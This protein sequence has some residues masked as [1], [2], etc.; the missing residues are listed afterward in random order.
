MFLLCSLQKMLALEK[1]V[2]SNGR[3]IWGWL[4]LI[5]GAFSFTSFLYAA[6]ISKLQPPSHNVIIR[7]IQNDWYFLRKLKKVKKSNGQVLAINEVCILSQNL[8]LL[9]MFVT[10]PQSRTGYHNMYKE[11]RDTTVEGGVEQMYTEMASRH[12]CI[13]I[14]KAV[15]VPAKLC[16]RECTKQFHNSKIKFPLMYR[17]VRPPT[18]TLKTT[19]VQGNPAQLICVRSF[20]EC[21]R[22]RLTYLCKLSVL[23][24]VDL[25][26]VS[27]HGLY[28]CSGFTVGR[29]YVY[30][31]T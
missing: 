18:R 17:K 8:I 21:W 4:F 13:Q 23:S 31:T 19:Y 29:G 28:P 5:V 2:A 3:I 27:Q 1:F 11:Y 30:Y 24:F 15:T 22:V 26:L 9:D 20:D 10:Q 6:V 7:A 16:K 25:Y 14:I 12:H